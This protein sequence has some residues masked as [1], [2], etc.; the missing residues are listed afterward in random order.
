MRKINRFLNDFELLEEYMHTSYGGI[1]TEDKV[2]KFIFL[3]YCLGLKI[4]NRLELSEFL[5]GN[6]YESLQKFV[7]TNE[8]IKNILLQCYKLEKNVINLMQD[9]VLK[10][11]LQ[12]KYD[13]YFVNKITEW[14][15][16]AN[17]NKFLDIF[18]LLSGYSRFF[19]DEQS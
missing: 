2:L 15:I 10:E 6:G 13:T 8:K 1:L 12:E 7:F 19:K 3:P 16:K 5:N 17:K 11:Y 9:D 4:I 14:N 18:S